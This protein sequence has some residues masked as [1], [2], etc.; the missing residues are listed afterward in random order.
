MMWLFDIAQCECVKV[1]RNNAVFS[2]GCILQVFRN[3]AVFRFGCI[4]QVSPGH[5]RVL[6]QWIDSKC[7]AL[8]QFADRGRCAMLRFSPQCNRP[9]FKILENHAGCII[10]HIIIDHMLSYDNITL[11]LFHIWLTCEHSANNRVVITRII[12]CRWRRNLV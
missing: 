9:N 3:N 2:F 8:H 1:F 7:S 4:L 5:I 10:K 11:N 12:C 6:P